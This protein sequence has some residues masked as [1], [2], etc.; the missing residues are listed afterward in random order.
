MRRRKP[1]AIDAERR[2]QHAREIRDQRL[3]GREQSLGVEA[4]RFAPVEG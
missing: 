4:A 3:F 2:E 1:P